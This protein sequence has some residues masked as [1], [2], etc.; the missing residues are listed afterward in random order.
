MWKDCV[1]NE[2]RYAWQ[3]GIVVGIGNWA[4]FPS[5]T[6]T[7]FQVMCLE[8][9]SNHIDEVLIALL[10]CDVTVLLFLV[11]FTFD[12]FWTFL[13][14]HFYSFTLLFAALM[15]MCMQHLF[16][17]FV[18]YSS[19]FFLSYFF[20]FFPIVPSLLYSSFFH[21]VYISFSFLLLILYVLLPD[22]IPSLSSCAF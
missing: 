8:N 17:L 10:N 14:S 9:I 3:F 15:W 11:I 7:V 22:F 20:S 2:Y 16:I 5:E 12:W 1:D 21:H 4:F 6:Q 13:Q 19:I 18:L